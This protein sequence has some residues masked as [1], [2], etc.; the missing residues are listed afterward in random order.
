MKVGTVTGK[1][2][3]TRRLEEL[4]NGALLEIDLI[5]DDGSV[6][7]ILAF[8]PLGAGE[9]E[10]V[11]V[12]QGSVA[13]GWFQ[14]GDAVID[15]L[16][17]GI[18]DEPATKNNELPDDIELDR[19]AQARNL[20]DQLPDNKELYVVKDL[21]EVL[22]LEP[23]SLREKLRNRGMGVGRGQ[24][25]IWDRQEVVELIAKLL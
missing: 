8:D 16:V 5:E 6:E 15:S 9:G 14:S 18:V 12:T 7:K 13:K 24:R 4:P 23:K 11:V 22:D 19:M 25:Y 3:T 20:A 1:I 21:V 17:I 10:R 2:W